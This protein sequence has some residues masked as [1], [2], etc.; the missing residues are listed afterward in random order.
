MT[1]I[2]ARVDR[3]FSSLSISS[4][5]DS[6]LTAAL[7][8]LGPSQ[9]AAAPGASR[10]LSLPTEIRL[11][12]YDYMTLSPKTIEGTMWTGAYF[13]C[14]QIQTEM[15]AHLKPERDVPLLLGSIQDGWIH[16][17]SQ[18]WGRAIDANRQPNITAIC[19]PT[20]DHLGLLAHV[21]V[22]MPSS[23]LS[24]TCLHQTLAALYK[25]YLEH[26]TIVITGYEPRLGTYGDLKSMNPAL[27][28]E[29]MCAGKVNC[30]KVTFSIEHLVNEKGGRHKATPLDMCDGPQGIPYVMTIVQNKI[31]KQSEKTFSSPTRFRPRS[32]AA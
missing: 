20:N 12:I 5:G 25:I 23:H 19:G 18:P 28:L 11:Q 9:R 1:T 22:T 32:L 7:P 3:L 6:L 17:P 15:K 24:C 27:F 8:M 4:P 21:A 29:Y 13:V 30:K 14:R 31:G 26:V 16:S 10:L 2:K